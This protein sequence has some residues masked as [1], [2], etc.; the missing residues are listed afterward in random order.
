MRIATVRPAALDAATASDLAGLRN[1]ACAVDAPHLPPETGETLALRLVHGWDGEGTERL[2]VGR[3]GHGELL[4]FAEL[5]TPQRENRELVWL[6]LVVDPAYRGRGVGSALLDAVGTV[7]AEVGR[8]LLMSSTWQHTPGVAF[9]TRH[10]FEQA[11][12]AAQRRL[13]P[14]QL[15]RPGDD[16]L[17]ASARSASGDY[18]T[19]R[20]AGPLPEDMLAAML[21]M[22]EQINDAPLDDLELE[23]DVFTV[24]RLRRYDAAQLARGQRLY[25]VVAIARDGSPAAHTVVAV[26]G[27]RP[28]HGEQ[29][30]TTVRR[31]HRGHRLGLRLKLE[32]LEW[33]REVEPQLTQVDTWPRGR[34]P[35]A[36][37][38]RRARP[39][40]RAVLRRHAHASSR[41]A[42]STMI[43]VMLSTP[44]ASMAA[45]HSS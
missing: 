36:A 3:D 34:V 12:V 25:R 19:T 6:N 42:S 24:D 26:D 2:L 31:E 41:E 23:D 29:H 8:P 43:T 10:G 4:G 16:D 45:R 11:S 28:Y 39:L 1:R 44:P 27:H 20:I 13:F 38:R 21:P 14:E 15:P 30:D 35:E 33:L 18:E 7:S 17:L 32:M 22:V 9:L 5:E 40:S 37:S